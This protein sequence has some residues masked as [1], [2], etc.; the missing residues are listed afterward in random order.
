[1]SYKK[2]Y[3]VIL[4]GNPRGGS[5][6]WNSLI[7]NVINPLNADLAIC[8]SEKFYQKSVLTKEAKYEWIFKEPNNW[9][10]YY[11]EHFNNNWKHFF[12]LGLKTGL[13]NSGSIHFAIKDIVLRNYLKIIENYDYMIYSRFDQFYVGKQ[14]EATT[15]EKK[16]Y[17]PAGEDYFGINDRHAIVE[18]S[19][20]KQFL[21]ICTYIDD[22]ISTLNPPKYLNC[23]SAYY[24]FLKEEDLLKYVYRYERSQFTTAQSID[25]TN[26]RVAKYRVYFYKD[27]FIKY[28]D[29]FMD[30]MKNTLQ[31]YN[32]YLVVF[33]EFRLFINYMYL[34]LR[35]FYGSLKKK[36]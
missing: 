15:S 2:N 22:D 3:L 11:E 8:T 26:W 36:N 34:K 6:T 24:R 16:I 19:V 33:S 31:K 35:R 7:Q 27:L 20:V 30:T 32:K 4:A 23:E 17:I 14:F 21:D 1:M 18:T 25:K 12:S 5:R 28:P 29:E 10:E 9:F 13:Y